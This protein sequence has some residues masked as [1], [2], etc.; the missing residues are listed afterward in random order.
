MPTLLERLRNDPVAHP[1]KDSGTVSTDPSRAYER[2][3][4][5]MGASIVEKRQYPMLVY[6]AS[7][8][9][10]PLVR[11]VKAARL[12]LNLGRVSITSAS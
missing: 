12:T 8:L 3:R 4:G 2:Q 1:W 6:D 10:L 9:G 5:E 11:F 7:A